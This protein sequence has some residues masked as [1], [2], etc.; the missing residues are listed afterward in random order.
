MPGRPFEITRRNASLMLGATAASL[1][2]RAEP[3]A[4][5]ERIN[6][7]HGWTGADNT[8]ALNTV[9]NA[10]NKSGAAAPVAPTP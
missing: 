3:A 10:Y 6:L 1:G 2:L 4:A 9:I 7:W 5:A 8:T